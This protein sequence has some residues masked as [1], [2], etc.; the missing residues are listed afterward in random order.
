MKYGSRR[1][2]FIFL[3]KN[4]D[5]LLQSV[6]FEFLILKISLILY[7]IAG[8]NN[9]STSTMV[10]SL[11]IIFT[12]VVIVILIVFYLKCW[13]RN[14]VTTRNDAESQPLSSKS[15]GSDQEKRV[16]MRQVSKLSQKFS[17]LTEWLKGQ[18]DKV[19]S[20]MDL[21]E[22]LHHLAYNASREIDRDQFEIGNEIGRGNFGRERVF[23]GS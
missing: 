1:I 15:V 11:S 20:E 4:L 18:P 16:T 8:M 13:K 21:K 3:Q 6:N 14:K 23:K 2:P 17:F 7:S 9:E 10:V 22:Q 12:L 19:N 5:W